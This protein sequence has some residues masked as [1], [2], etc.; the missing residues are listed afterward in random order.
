[1]KLPRSLIDVELAFSRESDSPKE[2]VQDRL[3][4]RAKDVADLLSEE[5]TYVYICGHKR[6][7]SGVGEALTEI[8]RDHRMDWQSLYEQM[9]NEGRYHVE[10]YY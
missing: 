1:M 2:Y 10:T 9:R 8:C 4:S 5:N 3:R 6:M 7:E